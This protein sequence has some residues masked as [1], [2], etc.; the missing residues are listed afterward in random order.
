MANADADAEQRGDDG[1]AH[2]DDRAEGD[3]QDDDGGEDADGLAGA[4]RGL[5]D[6]DRS[7]G[8]RARPRSPVA[9]PPRR[10]RRPSGRRPVGMSCGRPCRTARWR[11]RCAGSRW[12]IWTGRRRGRTGSATAATWGSAFELGRRALRSGLLAGRV[13]DRRRRVRNT[14]WALSPAWAGNRSAS[15]SWAC[16]DS[17][18]AAAELVLV[19]A[20]RSSATAP[21]PRRGPRSRDR[22]R[23]GAGRS[24]ARQTSEDTGVRVRVHQ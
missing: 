16:W 7:A 18:C 11:R 19:V 15:R 2:G 5:L 13:G 17:E 21:S 23:A 20:T 22:A 6:R 8:R 14:T 12:L 10:R 4:R 1:Q 9:G 3:E 24:P